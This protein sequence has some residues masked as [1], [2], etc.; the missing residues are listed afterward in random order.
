[1][2]AK[3]DWWGFNNDKVK[4]VKCPRWVKIKFVDNY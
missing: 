4:Q 1:M 3:F 2:K